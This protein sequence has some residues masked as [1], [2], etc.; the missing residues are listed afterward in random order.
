MLNKMIICKTPFG[1]RVQPIAFDK[2]TELVTAGKAR[3]INDRLY[4]QCDDE[5]HE[6][7]DIPVAPVVEPIY[8]TKVMAAE[9]PKRR[10]R[11][12]KEAVQ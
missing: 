8:A 9:L 10:G 1:R 5:E 4:E 12:R 11:P 3:K 2:V 7:D 6:T